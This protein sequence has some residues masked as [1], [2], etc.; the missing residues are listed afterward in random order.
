MAMMYCTYMV[1]IFYKALDQHAIVSEATAGF[2][3]TEQEAFPDLWTTRGRK[4]NHSAEYGAHPHIPLPSLHTVCTSASSKATLMP[5]PP[6]PA[7]I[8]PTI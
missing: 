1:W 7:M 8:H 5:L 4:G 6:P 3:L 2:R